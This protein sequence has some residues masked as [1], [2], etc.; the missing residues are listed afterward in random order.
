[1]PASLTPEQIT[2][3]VVALKFEKNTTLDALKAAIKKQPDDLVNAI[4]LQNLLITIS[5]I[6]RRLAWAAD[7]SLLNQLIQPLINLSDWLTDNNADL[8][9]DDRLGFF[10]NQAALTPKTVLSNIITTVKNLPVS[11]TP[12][13]I[14]AQWQQNGLALQPSTI[15]FEKKAAGHEL[16][17]FF[18]EGSYRD[19]TTRDTAG[20]NTSKTN[21]HLTTPVK[22][23]VIYDTWAQIEVLA[24]MALLKALYSDYSDN[25][26]AVMIGALKVTN[27]AV[28]SINPYQQEKNEAYKEAL[29][30]AYKNYG[31]GVPVTPEAV[32]IATPESS[33]S[34]EFSV[35]LRDKNRRPMDAE[36]DSIG[37]SAQTPPASTYS[38]TISTLNAATS[39]APL[40]TMAIPTSKAA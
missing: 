38:A 24:K 3:I 10:A 25:A 19:V 23:A 36:V 18:R 4:A 6:Q 13:S 39:M 29:D 33:K 15:R 40:I 27:K 5:Q 11:A 12:H 2:A 9:E 17:I 16:T 35:K 32:I 21:I 7:A 1:M 20:V 34:T 22:L 26:F 14:Q 31:F 30:R 37:S 28:T 8:I